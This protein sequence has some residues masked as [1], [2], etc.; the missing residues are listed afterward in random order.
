MNVFQSLTDGDLR[1]IGVTPFGARKKLLLAISGMYLVHSDLNLST[2]LNGCL[3]EIFIPEMNRRQ[4]P[5]SAAPG[6]E[7][8]TCNVASSGIAEKW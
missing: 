6:A 5:F 1:E 2:N 7:R 4:F 8:K 3:K